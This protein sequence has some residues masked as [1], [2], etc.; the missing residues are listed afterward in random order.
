MSFILSF[1]N[2][3]AQKVEKIAFLQAELEKL[4]EKLT[5]KNSELTKVSRE[6]EGAK[7][8][9]SLESSGLVERCDKLTQMLSQY[10][11]KVYSVS[12]HQ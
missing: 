12:Q 4:N 5:A 7:L 2:D 10:E 6:Y 8:N 9:F 1:Q 11:H 3:I